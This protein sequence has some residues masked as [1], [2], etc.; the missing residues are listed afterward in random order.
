[1]RVEETWQSSVLTLCPPNSL[2]III[3]GKDNLL[4]MCITAVNGK[5]ESVCKG[6][7]NYRNSMSIII[8]IL[9]QSS[10]ILIWHIMSSSS[11]QNVSSMKLGNFDF[12]NCN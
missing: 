5:G 7:I 8:N 2:I 9:P 10:L 3:N 4:L 6:K 1:M 11:H 12:I